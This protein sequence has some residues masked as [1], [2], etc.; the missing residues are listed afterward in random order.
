MHDAIHMI[1]RVGGHSVLA[2]LDTFARCQL[3]R[4][5]SRVIKVQDCV[6][7]LLVTHNCHPSFFN[8]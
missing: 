2:D 5:R 3:A 8:G 6:Y 7:G 4:R 1:A